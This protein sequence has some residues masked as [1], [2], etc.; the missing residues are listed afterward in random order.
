MAEE[1]PWEGLLTAEP[2]SR[3]A[4]ALGN[5]P[6]QRGPRTLRLGTGPG[7]G[8]GAS[9]VS[10]ARDAAHSRVVTASIKPAPL[11]VPAVGSRAPGGKCAQKD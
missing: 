3:G 10:W 7:W 8:G 11:R 2:R 1:G 9:L 4:G 6:G 5:D